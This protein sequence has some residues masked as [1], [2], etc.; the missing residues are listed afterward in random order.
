[1]GFYHSQVL[2]RLI[3]L[4][5]SQESIGA[6]RTELLKEARGTVLEIGFGSGTNLV[7]YPATI[8]KL[9]IVEPSETALKI[10][11]NAIGSAPFPVERVGDDGQKLKLETASVDT[12]VL[13]FTLCT[14]PDMDKTL[15]E[16]ARVLKRGGKLLFLEHGLSNNEKVARWQNRLNRLQ[17]SLCGGCNLNRKMDEAIKASPL[18]LSKMKTFCLPKTPRT[19]GSMYFGEALKDA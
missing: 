3:H 7:Y 10:A 12:V 9:L 11:Q 13:T 5:C 2:P 18:R 15:A 14:I 8:E 4:A 16:A 6:W 1:M 19:H 17:A